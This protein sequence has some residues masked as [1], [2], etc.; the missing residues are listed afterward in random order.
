MKCIARGTLNLPL[1]EKDDSKTNV[2]FYFEEFTI[3][4]ILLLKL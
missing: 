3:I 1:A 4:S 2:A